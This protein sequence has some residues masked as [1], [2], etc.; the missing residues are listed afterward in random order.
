MKNITYIICLKILFLIIF[1]SKAVSQTVIDNENFETGS[2]PFTYWNSGGIDC[3]LDT[4][5]TL[6][7]INCANLQ[8]N[9]GSVS[10][11]YTSDINL[12]S[13][14]KVSIE[15]DFRTAGFNWNH[16]FFIEFSNDSGASWHATPIATYVRN[17]SGF[18]NNT[19]YTGE[20]VEVLSSSYGGTYTF[21]AT[22]RLR[23]RADADNDNDDLF[24][25]NII[26]TGYPPAPE[27]NLQGNNVTIID[28]D[29]TPTPAD[30]TDFTTANAGI[31]IT[32]TFTIQNTGTASLNISSIVLSNTT[33]F[34]IIAPH[35][36][37]HTGT[38]RYHRRQLGNYR[39]LY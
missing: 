29:N 21:N 31:Q 34:T 33:D 24:I 22:S 32:R 39:T 1:S 37:Y 23:F 30:H 9:S 3:F 16:D 8:D 18:N 19:T 27:I 28:G 2:F 25:D 10:S 36:F 12:T 4:S 20:Y 26:I 6:S 7:G 35:S 5:S 17:G 14:A 38:N 11:M 15:F 13:Y